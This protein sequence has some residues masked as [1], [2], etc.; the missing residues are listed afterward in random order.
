MGAKNVFQAREMGRNLALE[1][2]DESMCPFKGGYWRSYWLEGFEG[3]PLEE[4][5]SVNPDEL[6]ID[7][8]E[9]GTLWAFMVRRLGL[10][11][12]TTDEHD[13]LVEEAL[14]RMTMS[15]ALYQLSEYL[16]EK[17]L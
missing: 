2:G 15:E 12:H 9:E 17:G 8:E 5:G 11:Q 10:P 6:D 7:E 3:V 14:D 16:K 1:G 4:R 13:A